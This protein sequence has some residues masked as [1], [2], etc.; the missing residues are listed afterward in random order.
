[1]PT[2]NT[3]NY[4][5]CTKGRNTA[6]IDLIKLLLHTITRGV[7]TRTTSCFC[8]AMTALRMATGWWN[9]RLTG[10]SLAFK[11]ATTSTVNCGPMHR[12]AID[13]IVLL[14]M[15][16]CIR[17]CSRPTCDTATEQCLCFR[18]TGHVNFKFS[19]GN[20]AVNLG[21]D[22]WNGFTSR[23]LLTAHAS[24]RKSRDMSREINTLHERTF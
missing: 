6:R 8:R 17:V 10:D 2:Q 24:N 1:M 4:V 9:Q 18:F 12:P 20:T 13:P 14:T 21:G 22:W 19:T 11:M 15:Y 23:R 7:E 5:K 3:A 16:K